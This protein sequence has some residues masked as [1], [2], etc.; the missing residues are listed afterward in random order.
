MTEDTLREH[1]SNEPT[2]KRH[3]KFPLTLHPTGQYCKKIRGKIYYFGK[4]KE[5]AL[6]LYH[7][8]A[9]YL[10]TVL[11]RVVRETTPKHQAPMTETCGT[12]ATGDDSSEVPAEGGWATWEPFETL[13]F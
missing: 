6:R 13:G 12:A 9:T 3:D 4:D 2:H 11:P 7:E 1:H 10:H 5:E 8:Q